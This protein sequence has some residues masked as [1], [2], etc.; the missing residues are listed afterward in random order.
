M[1]LNGAPNSK[2]ACEQD[3][4]GWSGINLLVLEIEQSRNC[5]AICMRLSERPI[6]IVSPPS[7]KPTL[8]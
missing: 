4:M 7:Y 6:S 5:E 2:M 8:L 1:V 3:E